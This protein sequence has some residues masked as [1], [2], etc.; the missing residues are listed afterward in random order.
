MVGVYYRPPNQ[1]EEA[2]EIF[3]KQLG[4]VSQ[5]LPLVLVGDFEL[6]NV[7]WK[8]NTAETKESRRFLECVEDNF[9]TQLVRKPTRQGTPLDLLFMNREELVGDVIVGDSLGHSNHEITD[10]LI[11]KE[12]RRGVQQNCLPWTSGGQTL[13]YLGAWW[14]ESLGR[15]S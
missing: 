12:V 4:E 2:D 5:S 6:P 14:T 13:A 3:Y 10:L 7:C 1:D 15:Q 11:L 8:Y 9:L